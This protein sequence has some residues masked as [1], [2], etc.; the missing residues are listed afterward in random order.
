MVILELSDWCDPSRTLMSTLKRLGRERSKRTRRLSPAISTSVGASSLSKWPRTDQTGHGAM[1]DRRR[2][3]DE[4]ARLPAICN[5][6][7]GFADDS[8]LF[9]R[10]GMFG[11]RYGAD[12]VCTAQSEMAC[13]D[14]SRWRQTKDLGRIDGL[15]C[16]RVG[17]V[18]RRREKLV[19]GKRVVV[20][21][22]E[23]V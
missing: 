7:L 4:H 6:D 13:R 2:E 14:I 21:K 17:A 18:R 5:G 11:V 20:E 12:Q 1:R 23:A 9:E 8:E 10:V 22:V 15:V 19:F 16:L 3:F